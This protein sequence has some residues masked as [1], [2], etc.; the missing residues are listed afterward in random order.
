MEHLSP[1]TL[2]LIR[3]HFPLYPLCSYSTLSPPTAPAF[4]MTFTCPTNLYESVYTTTKQCR[5]R[6]D[7][8]VSLSF[9][10]SFIICIR[11]CFFIHVSFYFILSISQY[12]R[13]L[14][15]QN[16]LTISSSFLIPPFFKS[17]RL[18]RMQL[19]NS[20]TTLHRSPGTNT[21]SPMECPSPSSSTHWSKKSTSS[22]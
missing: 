6:S 18:T 13:D 1:L 12:F 8:K 5:E 17:N 15:F 21:Q 20:S 14:K 9:A 22:P 7:I 3:R 2:H 10:F 19:F 11:S 16:V 4:T